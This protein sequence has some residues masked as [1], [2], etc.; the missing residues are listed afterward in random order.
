MEVLNS[1]WPLVQQVLRLETATVATFV[2]QPGSGQLALLIVLTAGL[3]EA[4]GNSVVLFVNRVRPVRFLM[5][6]LVAS[7]IFTFTYFF[8]ALTVFL[9]ARLAFSA[10][11]S[12]PLV[13]QV[14]AFGFA[15]RVF[16]FLEFLPVLGRPLSALLR[17]WSLL[18]VL[19]L[20]A[21]VLAL[22]PWQALATVGLGAVVLLTMQ[23]TIG[24]PLLLLA[25]WFR[26][27]A[28]G[29]ELVLDRQ[30]LRELLRSPVPKEEQR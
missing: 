27:R 24:R 12:F 3:S 16:G 5:T 13:L 28:A 11:G 6:L 29:R 21:E 19:L 10:S 4:V 23:Q 15:P 18:A 30:G 9:V 7:I 8:W 25:N 20:T 2:G 17:M 14:I 22:R 26:T 1:F